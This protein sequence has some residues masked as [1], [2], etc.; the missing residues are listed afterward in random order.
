MNHPLGILK[1]LKW[2]THKKVARL[3]DRSEGIKK[4]DGLWIGAHQDKRIAEVSRA[5]SRCGYGHQIIVGAVKAQPFVADEKEGFVFDDAATETPAEGVGFKCSSRNILGV[6][7]KRIG[8]K[9]FI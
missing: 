9:V 1:R 4:F 8:V 3:G 5:L 2:C 7:G 6:V